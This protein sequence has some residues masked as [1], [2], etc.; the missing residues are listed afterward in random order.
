M[1]K[2]LVLSMIAVII[3]I[4]IIITFVN[5][6]EI[7]D[8]YTE[9][10]THELELLVD[11]FSD[12][13]SF[14]EQY[15]T[16]FIDD[17]K[18]RGIRVTAIDVLG[19]VI[20]DTDK[21][22]TEMQNH[23]KRKE[24]KE[25]LIGEIG[26]DVRYSNTIRQNYLY[27]ACKM[28]NVSNYIIRLSIKLD[29]INESIHGL[30][31]SL[32]FIISVGIAIAILV[33]LRIINYF[34][35][36][37][38]KLSEASLKIANDIIP[39]KFNYNADDEIGTLYKNFNVMTVKLNDSISEL[40]N[41]NQFLNSILSNIQ[42]G[43]IA[44]N[45]HREIIFINERCRNILDLR[46]SDV[47]TKDIAN[48]VMNYEI[49]SFVKS[50]FEDREND[51]NSKIELSYHSKVIKLIINK[52][53]FSEDYNLK[54][55][56]GAVIL[57]EDITQSHL[58]DEMRKSFVA[59]VTHELKTPLTSIKGFAETI[60]NNEI[61]DKSKID[62]FMNIID[63]E[64]DRLR[65]LIDDTLL[66]SEIE[67]V[68]VNNTKFKIKDLVSEIK[69][70]FDHAAEK[71]NILITYIYDENI[72]I[73]LDRNR[74]KQLLINLIDN[75]VKYNKENGKILVNINLSDNKKKLHLSVNDTGIGIKK[76]DINRIFERFYRVDK[77]RSRKMGGTGLGLA[78]VKHI[79]ISFNGKIDVDSEVE[80]GTNIK[81]N[82]PIND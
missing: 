71:S 4:N 10:K 62:R 56:Y 82:I 1:K 54:S 70:L 23:L 33:L 79:V 6:K 77:S 50:Y 31:K 19:N 63:T 75:A 68:D 78:I 47:V 27:V 60:R 45:F 57:I 26:T 9:Q 38:E 66:L 72:E 80:K 41:T 7:K 64:A 14:D 22:A 32:Y 59:N 29:A 49:N 8:S 17:L 43:V 35:K 37:V 16:S 69:T 34:T 12:I 51:S 20:F 67:T 81:I 53:P 39:E 55:L 15:T 76:D 21:N 2:K 74:L 5:I 13:N 3:T 25:A 42:S 28:K 11:L 58:L 52:L 30:T 65:G 24:I 48:V 44:L 46:D 61:T 36:P 18:N 73:F 40:K